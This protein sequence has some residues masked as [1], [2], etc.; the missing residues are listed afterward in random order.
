MFGRPSSFAFPA[1]HL[2]GVYATEALA[3]SVNR[4]LADAVLLGNLG[5]RLAVSLAQDPN[6]LLLE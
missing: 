6:H 5:H 3:P 2:V 4:L 1:F